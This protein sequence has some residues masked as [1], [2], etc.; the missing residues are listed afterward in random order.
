LRHGEAVAIGMALDASYAAAVGLAKAEVADRLIA[1]LTRLQLPATPPEGVG[2]EDLLEGIEEFRE[3][4]GGRLSITIP[5]ELGKCAG[6]Q[7][8]DA[9]RMRQCIE[10]MLCLACGHDQNRNLC[11]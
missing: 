8:V 5:T 2:M 6:I 1:L 7:I 4:L 9:E 10:K 3:H 11:G